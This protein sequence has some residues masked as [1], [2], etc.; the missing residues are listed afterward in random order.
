MCILRIDYIFALAI[1]REGFGSARRGAGVVTEQIA[2]LST[3]N[4]CQGS[5]PCLSAIFSGYSEARLSRLLWEQEIAGSN[6]ATP[7]NKKTNVDK[8]AG[9]FRIKGSRSSAG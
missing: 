1:P 2:N 5:N 3:G 8:T 7:T 6:P 4:G 9:L